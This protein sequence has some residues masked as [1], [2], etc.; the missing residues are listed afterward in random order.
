[1]PVAAFQAALFGC[2]SAALW[3]RP[4]AIPTRIEY[5]QLNRPMTRRMIGHY[6]IL[7]KL[8]DGVV[9]DQLDRSESDL[10]PIDN[11]R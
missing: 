7:D 3:G 8:G 6:E 9:Y 4:P 1:M 10:M 2:G 11:F 5:H